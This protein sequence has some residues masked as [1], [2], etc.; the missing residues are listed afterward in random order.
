MFVVLFHKKHLRCR[1]I[2]KLIV[3]ININGY[4]SKTMV[5][6][7]SGRFVVVLNLHY[8]IHRATAFVRCPVHT[9]RSTA[10][11]IVVAVAVIGD[12]D[13]NDDDEEEKEEE[14][15]EWDGDEYDDDEEEEEEEEEGDGDKDDDFVVFDVEPSSGV[16]AFSDF[17]LQPEREACTSNS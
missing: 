8:N 14:E 9:R 17:V 6:P 5:C 11:N 16:R 3:L 7:L 1:F 13:D 15:E 2:L 12:R 4:F 10:D